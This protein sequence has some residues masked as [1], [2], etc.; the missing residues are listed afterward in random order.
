M[1]ELTKNETGMEM[2]VPTGEMLTAI[3]ENMGGQIDFSMIDRVRIPSGGGRA[4]EVP[5]LD[6]VEP[7]KAVSGVLLY[8]KYQNVYWESSFED[9]S[10]AQPDCVAT[11][12]KHGAG[13]P[14]GLCAS[15]PFNEFGSA[16]NGRGK[17]CRNTMLLFLQQPGRALPLA[18]L[19]PPTS[20]PR[21]KKYLMN[22][23]VYGVPYYTAITELT[24]EQTKSENGIAYSIASPRLVEKLP[25]D[26]IQDVVNYRKSIIPAFDG[27]LI[28]EE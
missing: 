20:I 14:G 3:Q 6:G 11:D 10:G 12:G 21:M 9:N 13:M 25:S 15:C 22:L 4:W 8:F 26:V 7:Q 17:K 18:V 1:K 2:Y 23:T 24:L 16:E 27:V 28:S 19:L 5:T